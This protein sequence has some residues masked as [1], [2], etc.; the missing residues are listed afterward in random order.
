MTKAKQY[1]Q[2]E[3]YFSVS[4]YAG[5]ILSVCYWNRLDPDDQSQRVPSK[6]TGECRY[7]NANTQ[8]DIKCMH[9]T[10]IQAYRDIHSH[11]AYV[12]FDKVDLLNFVEK[13]IVVC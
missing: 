5:L 6:L 13:S 1:H 3:M 10:Y 7:Y 8:K 12:C 11:D 9:F 4:F 2:L